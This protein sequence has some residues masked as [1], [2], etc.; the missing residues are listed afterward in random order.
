M[1]PLRVPHQ[2]GGS[3]PPG[4]DPIPNHIKKGLAAHLT[5]TLSLTTS[6]RSPRY[7]GRWVLFNDAKV[8]AS[9]STPLHLGYIYFYK[10]RD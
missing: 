5:L 3:S 2:E 1:R 8:A 10:R 6:N 9:E 7:Q 4:P